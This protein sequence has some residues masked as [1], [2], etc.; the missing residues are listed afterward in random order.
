MGSLLPLLPLVSVVRLL[1]RP[2]SLVLPGWSSIALGFSGR[3]V[4]LLLGDRWPL[5]RVPLRAPSR[6]DLGVLAVALL[7]CPGTFHPAIVVLDIVDL[8]PLS[9]VPGEVCE[10]SSAGATGLSLKVN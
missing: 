2:S 3:V 8:D 4:V 10:T 6:A 9:A 1:I 5:C 7:R